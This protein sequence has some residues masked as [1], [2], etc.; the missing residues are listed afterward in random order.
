MFTLTL[1]LTLTLLGLH[2]S[3]VHCLCSYCDCEIDC[4][5]KDDVTGRWL[6]SPGCYTGKSTSGRMYSDRQRWPQDRFC[7]QESL[8]SFKKHRKRL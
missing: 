2:Y 7:F 3:R 4:V 8:S 5:C 1:T 6:E